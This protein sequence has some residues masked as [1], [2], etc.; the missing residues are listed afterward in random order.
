LFYTDPACPWSWSIEPSMRRL[1]VE[2]GD[3]IDLRP[4]MGGLARQFGDPLPVVADW[5]AAADASGMPVD[6]RLWIEAPP[7]SSYP[8]CLA[9]KAAGEQGADVEAAY[10]RALREG[11]A[12][13]RHKLDGT[14]ALVAAA[15]E[16]PGLDVSRFRIDLQSNAMTELFAADIERAQA[17]AGR[18]DSGAARPGSG[19]DSG[20]A[21]KRVRLPTVEFHANDGAIHA[22]YG[23]QPYEAYRAAA[24]A[25]G[26]EGSGAP[27]PTFEQ[28]LRRFGTMATP[29]VAAVCDL[30]G[31]RAAAELWRMAGEWRV[32]F[33][34][35]GGGELW[36]PA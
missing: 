20:G 13:R 8:A 24:E 29:E 31:P 6:P 2:F 4:V 33:E 26:A 14:E 11:F 19:V 36:S 17:A 12:A 18:A 23:P 5:L 34:R 21:S 15:R 28:A 35:S 10:L 1:V 9:V 16:V 25:A 27:A 3:A 7:V 22:V 30:P 32:R